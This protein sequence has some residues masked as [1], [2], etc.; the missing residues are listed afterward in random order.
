MCCCVWSRNLVNG[1]PM[2]HWELPRLL[3]PLKKISYVATSP[4]M[5]EVFKREILTVMLE[6]QATVVP[7]LWSCKS[8]H[9][10]AGYRME[11]GVKLH[12]PTALFSVK[13]TGII[14][15]GCRVGPRSGLDVYG[16]TSYASHYY[17]GAESLSTIQLLCL[18]KNCFVDTNRFRN[19]T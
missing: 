16:N 14:W 15:T 10:L 11:V 8:C 3:P 18:C 2:A 12:A 1:E 13:N 4:K 9:P 6:E 5:D 17:S 7:L 19:L